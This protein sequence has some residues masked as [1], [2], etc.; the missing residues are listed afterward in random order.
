MSIT[1]DS[2]VVV[3]HY[4]RTKPF[5]C[6]IVS[7]QIHSFFTVQAHN[8]FQMANGIVKGDP[9]IIAKLSEKQ[10]VKIYGGHVI[11]VTEEAGNIIILPDNI[12]YT[13]ERREH[14]RYPVSLHGYIKYG[15]AGE[16]TSPIF[17]KDLS[18]SGFRI[19]TS[20]DLAVEDSIQIDICSNY[21]VLNVE[22]IVV[23]KSVNYGRNEYGVQ[24]IF[25][26]KSAI[27]AIR[28]CL[29]S[30]LNNEKDLILKCLYKL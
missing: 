12:G 13:E 4:F 22:A 27:K 15:S 29:D 3:R 17:I 21:H 11:T 1:S 14:E 28:D 6:S 19:Y 18:H 24:I 2:L 30:L 7:G 23:R 5:K 9:I 26:S 10:D 8:S 20:A 25:R 16:C